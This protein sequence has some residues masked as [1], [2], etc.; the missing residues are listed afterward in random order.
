MLHQNPQGAQAQSALSVPSTIRF[1]RFTS[2]NGSLNKSFSLDTDGHPIKT[3]NA[4]LYSGSVDTI[5]IENIDEFAT[6]LPTLKSNQALSYGVCKRGDGPLVTK[7]AWIDQG[8]PRH[9]MVRD[10]DTFVWPA[11]AGLMM[12]DYDPPKEGAALPQDE[13]LK[14]LYS[15]LPEIENAPHLWWPSAGSCVHHW[16][17]GV[18]VIPIR[19]QRVYVAVTAA[20]EIERLGE[21]LTKRLWLAGHGRVEIG[22]AGQRLLRTCVDAAVFQ[23]ERLDF[24]AGATCVAPLTQ[25]RGAPL[26]LGGSVPLNAHAV[27][28]VS[29]VE[30]ERYEKMIAAARAAA[31]D[32][33]QQVRAAYVAARAPS[34]ARPGVSDDA[35]RQLLDAAADG[36]LLGDFVLLSAEGQQVTVTDLLSNRS[37]WHGRRFHDPLEPDYPDKRIARVDL[38]SGGQPRLYSHIHGGQSYTLS[39]SQVVIELTSGGTE[40]AVQE[41]LAVLARNEFYEHDSAVVVAGPRGD[42]RRLGIYAL[43]QAVEGAVQYTRFDGRSKPPRAKPVDCPDDIARRIREMHDDRGLRKIKGVLRF[44][45]MTATGRIIEKPGYDSASGLLLLNPDGQAWPAI[46]SAP[47]KAEALAA[48]ARIW[49]PF[50]MFPFVDAV[51]R[52]VA[53]AAIFTAVIRPSLYTAP[54]FLFSAPMAGSGK[55]LFAACVVALAGG[56]PMTALPTTDE[57]TNKSLIAS[58]RSAPAALFYDNVSGAVGCPS[59]NMLITGPTYSGRILGVSQNTTALPTNVFIAMTGNNCSPRADMCRRLLVATIDA[60]VEAP[61]RR[62]FLLNPLEYVND[63]ILELRADVLTVYVARF[64]TGAETFTDTKGIDFLEWD[65][66]ARQTVVWAG[67]IEREARGADAYNFGDPVDGVE[68]AH[69]NDETTE[70]LDDVLASMELAQDGRGFLARELHSAKECARRGE[71]ADQS[72]GSIDAVGR[73]LLDVVEWAKSP[74]G[75]ARWLHEQCGRV[76]GGRRLECRQDHARNMKVWYV[77][78]MPTG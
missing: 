39:R 43:K 56:A 73:A 68:A 64:A 69:A 75:L 26:R 38:C 72:P 32:E 74:R 33:A 71:Y 27:K 52:G 23:P 44:P 13:L 10:R 2:T 46:P 21:T 57:E 49:E 4:I 17:T 60:R 12:V 31:A 29:A 30:D 47:T 14:T 63:N 62:E 16:E 37:V 76:V 9:V 70:G 7:D 15:A 5:E 24:A 54:A 40:R 28:D 8:S 25:R 36:R 20:R 61:Y 59:L 51:S 78:R 77:Q 3:A 34:M 58:L 67:Q 11:G 35:V 55:T 1:S 50:R 48:I 19:G 18:E 6:L 66:S 22:K 42:L 45:T 65:K 41:T 53:L